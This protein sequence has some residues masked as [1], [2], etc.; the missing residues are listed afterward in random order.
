MAS[1]EDVRLG[2]WLVCIY[3]AISVYDVDDPV[4]DEY[5]QV[6]SSAKAA[7]ITVSLSISPF[8]EILHPLPQRFKPAQRKG[9]VKLLV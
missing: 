4:F 2:G 6:I 1:N 5:D 7:P 8:H 9:D 3:K